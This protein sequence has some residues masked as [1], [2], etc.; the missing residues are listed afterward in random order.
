MPAR[1]LTLLV[2]GFSK[3]CASVSFVFRRLALISPVQ[4]VVFSKR[5]VC[6]RFQEF[7]GDFQTFISL[8][9]SLFARFRRL[10]ALLE[11]CLALSKSRFAISESSLALSES[12]VAAFGSFFALSKS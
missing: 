7:R 6:P 5:K 3:R 4:A 9:K 8:S 11:S 1:N 12:P 2:A 10:L